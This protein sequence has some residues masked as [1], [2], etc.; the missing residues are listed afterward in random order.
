GR[1]TLVHNVETVYWMPEILAKG[2]AAFAGLGKEG[3]KGIR[4]YS[5]SG[6]IKLPGVVLAPA[7]TTANELIERTGGMLD[8]HVFKGYLAGRATGRHPA[9]AAGGPAARFRPAREIWFL[10]R[11]PCGGDPVGQGQHA[12]RR[13][14]SAAV[15][16]G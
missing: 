9:G 13:S 12:R 4:S 5:V 15:L 7:G 14:Q 6:R 8:G 2:A 11:Q 16:R 3:H 10:R 1:P